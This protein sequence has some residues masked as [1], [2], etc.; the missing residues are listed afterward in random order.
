MSQIARLIL[1]MESLI[2]RNAES[3]E[4]ATQRECKCHCGGQFHGQKHSEEWIQKTI[5][6]VVDEAW[7]RE[8]IDG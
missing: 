3:C 5:A 4:Q 8:E 6:Q 2:R 7:E 1:R